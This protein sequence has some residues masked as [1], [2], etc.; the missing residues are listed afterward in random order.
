MNLTF[1]SGLLSE[2]RIIAFI[3]D[4]PDDASGPEVAVT[5]PHLA[6][7][8]LSAYEMEA[9]SSRKRTMRDN[10]ERLLCEVTVNIA[11]LQQQSINLI[12]V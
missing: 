9:L 7:T 6:G 8:G 12:E 3:I 5:T 10:R 2:A 11:P 4:L 1:E